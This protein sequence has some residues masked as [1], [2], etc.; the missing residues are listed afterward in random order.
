MSIVS[1]FKF[2]GDV[3]IPKNDERFF[4]RGVTKNGDKSV[5]LGFTVKENGHN[6]AFV[7]LFGMAT[8]VIKTRSVNNDALE[9]DW[10]DRFDP[11]I[12]S[13]VATYRKHY[14]DD[15]KNPD[16]PRKEFITDYDAII[17][18]HENLQ[19]DS[20]VVVTGT[21]EKNEYKGKISDK[22]RINNL[23]L[24][25]K[26][27]A[28]SLTL[29]MDFFYNKDSIDEG[30][31]KSDKKIYVNG[32]M[33]QYDS[34][35][36]KNMY[37]PQT[38]VLSAGMF[39]FEN[40]EHV[41]KWEYRKRYLDKTTKSKMYHIKW[42]CRYVSGAE[43]MPFDESML[44]AA[45]KEQ[46]AFG[47]K[48]IDDFKPRNGVYGEKIVEVRLK[49]PELKGEFENGLVE[50]DETLKEFKENIFAPMTDESLEEV[51]EAVAAEKADKPEPVEDIKDETVENL[52]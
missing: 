35:Y 24:V 1:K 10:N 18:L 47:I 8:N 50:C 25:S 4:R 26:D 15:L 2:T 30:S 48:T 21:W 44:T 31:F 49:D 23:Y 27:T 5:S 29:T 34:G 52:F 12:V 37:F 43:E 42:D 11:E 17:Y 33:S 40:E 3:L 39:D 6:A 32:Y 38:A 28:P 19:R 16:A 22:F 13:S 36:K 51:M 20:R 9:I 45:Q 46:I 41:K 7:T 14:I